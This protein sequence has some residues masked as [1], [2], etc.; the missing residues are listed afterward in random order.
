MISLQ[1]NVTSLFAQNNLNVDNMFQSQT[2]QQLTSG[3]RINSSADDAAGLAVANAYASSIAELQQGVRNANDGLSQLQIVDGGL[4]NIST[5][6]NRMKTLATESATGTFTGNR[7][8]L[9]TEFQDLISE[10][11]RQAGNIELNSGG[12][13]NASLTVYIGGVL[14]SNTGATASPSITINLS[15]SGNAV[16]S[17][18]LGLTT[19][20]TNVAVDSQTGAAA[21][22]TAINTAVKDLGQ[23]QGSVGAAEN[24]LNY[25]ISLAQSQISNFSAAQS[26][27]KDTDVAAAAANLSKA[28]V[29]EQASIAAMAQ[30]NSSPQAVLKLLQ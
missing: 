30:A 26:Q 4:S 13:L 2:I 28:Q 17:V 20:T 25:A 21:A 6:L 19:G 14:T 15:G 18:S 8:T 9:N 23:V 27:I 29:L 12:Q 1:T 10:I 7:T 22:I 16:D 3:Y 24:T 11:N 5:M